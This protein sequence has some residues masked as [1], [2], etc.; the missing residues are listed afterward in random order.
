[1]TTPVIIAGSGR[2]GTTWVL[3]SL[4]EANRM[5]TVFEPL[6]PVGVPAAS[7]FAH[8]YIRPEAQEPELRAFMDRVFSGNMRS[9]WANYRIRPDR[10]N[11]LRHG[12]IPIYLHIRKSMQLLR[13]YVFRRD[14]SGLI[15]KFIRANL[16]LPW[17]ARQ[18]GFPIILVVRHPCAV[19]A[20]RLNLSPADW[21]A[22][23][24]LAR[25][26]D[27]KSVYELI[28]ERFG[29]DLAMPM[30]AASALSC[31]WCIENVL[32]LEWAARENYGVVAYESLLMHPETEW[33]RV[34]RH[35]G[36]EKIPTT[37]LLA[38]PSQQSA[39]DMRG[40]EFTPEHIERWRTQLRPDAIDAVADMMARF[41]SDLYS[42]DSAMPARSVAVAG[43]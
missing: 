6:H 27:D 28:G 8:R 29:V 17:L 2:S 41:G 37:E 42:V 16:M 39:L 32:P 34:A 3:D 22:E 36:L 33:W 25:Y 19:V 38:A 23:K 43:G 9:L 15:V 35:L 4:A 30:S 5:R 18:Y 20:S 24:A 12:P 7:R 1:M 26:R 11:P 14:L 31:V 21:S 13:K 10:F 40:R